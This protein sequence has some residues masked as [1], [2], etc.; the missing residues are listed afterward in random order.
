MIYILYKNKDLHTSERCLVVGFVS[1]GPG[2]T[3]TFDKWI[4]SPLVLPLSP[5]TTTFIDP[6]P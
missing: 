4:M 1:G 6:K 2:K 5:V 3:R